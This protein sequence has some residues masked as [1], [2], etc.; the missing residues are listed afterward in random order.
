[1]AFVQ[2]QVVDILPKENLRLARAIA[3]IIGIG[4]LVAFKGN[5]LVVGDLRLAI[6][7]II[8]YWRKPNLSRVPKAASVAPGAVNVVGWV[9]DLC[10]ALSAAPHAQQ[11]LLNGRANAGERGGCGGYGLENSEGSSVEN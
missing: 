7:F 4:F 2:P 9:L 11:D 6:A 5:R 10:R 1:M 8:V 3:V